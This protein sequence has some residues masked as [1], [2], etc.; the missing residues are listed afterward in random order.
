MNISV[1]PK[2][3]K[4]LQHQIF[5]NTDFTDPF[6]SGSEIFDMFQE[7]SR[8]VHEIRYMCSTILKQCSMIGSIKMEN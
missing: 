4:V 2:V 1:S 5:S 6:Q 3:L 8:L 7:S